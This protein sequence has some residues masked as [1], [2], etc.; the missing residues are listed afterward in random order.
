MKALEIIQYMESLRDEEQR[1]VLMRF[2]KTGPGQYGE[3]DVGIEI[4]R[5]FAASRIMK[6]QEKTINY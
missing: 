3:S 1:Q 5:I 6:K 4:I 2:F